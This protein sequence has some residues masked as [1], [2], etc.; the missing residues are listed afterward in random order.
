MK[1]FFDRPPEDV[2]PENKACLCLCRGNFITKNIPELKCS[3]KL[4][5][6]SFGN[7]DFLKTINEKE[8]GI[9]DFFENY[10]FK[11]G[12]FIKRVE[13]TEREKRMDFY[14]AQ[15]PVVTYSPVEIYIK[16]DKDTN[17]VHISTK[18][19]ESI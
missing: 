15:V 6:E 11:N 3:G 4:K 8:L 18:S 13:L 10:N 9:T 7:L 2:C 16:K 19:F 12:F 1:S 5:C 17:I 14:P